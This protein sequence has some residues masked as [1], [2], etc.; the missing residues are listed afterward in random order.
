MVLCRLQNVN[1]TPKPPLLYFARCTSFGTARLKAPYRVLL[2]DVDGTWSFSA[3]GGAPT[4]GG[5]GGWFPGGVPP[6]GVVVE[7]GL[8]A[9]TPPLA[10]K[11][12]TLPFWLKRWTGRFGRL[13]YVG[14]FS[15]YLLVIWDF[16]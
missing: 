16:G 3:T 4:C 13:S 10:R 8:A 1:I 15:L 11:Q 6:T 12:V 14:C 7:G 2:R 5:G 9:D